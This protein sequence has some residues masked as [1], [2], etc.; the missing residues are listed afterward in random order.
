MRSRRNIECRG[1]AV[2]LA[3]VLSAVGFARGADGTE[4]VTL[5]VSAGATD[6]EGTLVL[7]EL[8]A[9]LRDCR[10]LTL[11][12]VDTGQSLPVQVDRTEKTRVAWIVQD[13]LPADQSRRY[14]LAAA[15]TAAPAGGVRFEDDGKHLL[16]RVGDKPFLT[17]N[18][19]VVASPNPKEPYYARSGYIHPLLSPSG[20]TITDDFNPDHAHQHGVMFAWRKS[21]FEGRGADCWDQK[22]GQGRV[23][24][25]RIEAAASG[26]V[27]GSFVARLRHVSLTVPDA[28]KPM[29]DETWLVRVHNLSGQFFLFD[30]ESTQT[31]AGQSPFTVEQYLYGAMAIRGARAWSQS[32]PGQFDFLTSEGRT[33]KDGD[34][35]RPRWVDFYGPIDGRPAGVLVM[36]HPDN[37]RFPQPVRLHPSL[38]YFCFTPASLGA[39]TIEPG[40]PYVSRYRFVV[41][42]GMLEREMIERLWADY[43][44]PPK[45]E[46]VGA[47]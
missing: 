30:L 16:A 28:P 45:V 13:R 7:A 19:A 2:A 21:R 39:F 47:R 44:A 12:R 35:S 33:R 10:Q 20:R 26:P 1:A 15:V 41:H 11:S 29:L 22:T 38:P 43:A 36:D 37:F 40:K 27:F 5:A 25:V 42:D 14:R 24:H 23:E 31:C 46:I 17:Y 32:R 18:S 9:A 3:L 34:Q 8:P 6:R 4:A